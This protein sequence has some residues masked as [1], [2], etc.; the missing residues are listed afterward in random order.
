MLPGKDKA[1]RETHGSAGTAA[2][3]AR[4]SRDTRPTRQNESHVGENDICKEH[5]PW[6]AIL[7][8][9]GAS[10]LWSH[11]VSLNQQSW[12]YTPRGH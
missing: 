9:A 6:V 12:R 4:P 2:A 7:Y 11:Y 8:V 3:G 10:F 1:S 5:A